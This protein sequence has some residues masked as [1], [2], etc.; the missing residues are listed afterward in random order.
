MAL[1][2]RVPLSTWQWGDMAGPVASLALNSSLDHVRLSFVDLVDVARRPG[3]EL[4][5]I[6]V[7]VPGLGPAQFGSLVGPCH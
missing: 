3:T 1:W 6:H 2:W 5:S 7:G 4:P